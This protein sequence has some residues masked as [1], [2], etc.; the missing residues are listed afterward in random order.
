MTPT[1]KERDRIKVTDGKYAGHEGIV[2]KMNDHR[3]RVKLDHIGCKR[4]TKEYC[5][6]VPRAQDNGHFAD[7]SD[8]DSSKAHVFGMGDRVEIV[9]GPHVG[10]YGFI[11]SS[12]KVSN[13]ARIDNMGRRCIDH[14]C[15]KPLVVS[16]KKVATFPS[17]APSRSRRSTRVL[18]RQSAKSAALRASAKTADILDQSSTD[19]SSVVPSETSGPPANISSRKSTGESLGTLSAQVEIDCNSPAYPDGSTFQ[20]LFDVMATGLSTMAESTVDELSSKLFDRIQHFRSMKS[21]FEQFNNAT[22]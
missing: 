6:L 8:D 17:H 12:N 14:H 15:L 1:I 5:K 18:S 10:C 4:I 2:R 9:S 19:G 3:H 13:M 16:A 7:S 20:E 21:R 22:S 11:L